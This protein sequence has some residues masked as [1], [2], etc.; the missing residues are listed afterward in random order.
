MQSVFLYRHYLTC[1]I[2][3]YIGI[4]VIFSITKAVALRNATQFV[5]PVQEDNEILLKPHGRRICVVTVF[6]AVMHTNFVM[7]PN[8][9]LQRTIGPTLFLAAFIALILVI[10]RS[11]TFRKFNPI[12]CRTLAFRTLNSLQLKQ[13]DHR[14]QSLQGTYT[15]VD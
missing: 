15:A 9:A 14:L 4:V 2:A 13:A 1:P 10:W 5:L 12:N 8:G 7:L 3:V 11:K 6:S